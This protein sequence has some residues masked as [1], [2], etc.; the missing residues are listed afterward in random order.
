MA[1]EIRTTA[2]LLAMAAVV[3]MAVFGPGC[4]PSYPK[5]DV[6]EDCHQGEFCVNGLCQQC[7]GDQDCAAGQ[8]CASGA[9]QATPGYCTSTSDCGPGQDC[10]NNT[11]VTRQES[12]AAPQ[13][14]SASGPCTL[15]PIYFG[16][17]QDVLDESARSQ[18]ARA[19]DCI[20][21]RG[22]GAVHMTGMTDPRG[23]EEYNLALGDRRAQSAK[24]YLQSLAVSSGLSA[25][26]MGEE[27][28]TGTDE[29]S[30]SRDRR[31]D[32]TER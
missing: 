18:L 9:C 17:D 23:T 12:V 21:Q 30:W 29:G 11:C 4:G 27:L 15:D 13:A 10:E 3:A 8:T 16:F 26:S 6:D 2:P 5:C 19:A 28:A 25:S 14:P 20:K 32:L 1:T 7:R 22:L 24:K 31:V